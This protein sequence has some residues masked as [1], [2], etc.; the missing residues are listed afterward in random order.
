ML[1]CSGWR[2][3]IGIHPYSSA[4]HSQ[5]LHKAPWD[6]QKC[7]FFATSGRCYRHDHRPKNSESHTGN[8]SLSCNKWPFPVLLHSQQIPTCFCLSCCP[9]YILVHATLPEPEP[10]THRPSALLSPF[11]GAAKTMPS[12]VGTAEP[13]HAWVPPKAT[14]PKHQHCAALPKSLSKWAIVWEGFVQKNQLLSSQQ[15][16]GISSSKA[17]GSLLPTQPLSVLLDNTIG[18]TRNA[19]SC[20][21]NLPAFQTF[22]KGTRKWQ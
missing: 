7:L 13:L 17:T 4:L 16:L 8:H 3:N 22:K 2:I 15:D 21:G 12:S 1:V 19:P 9:L 6:K 10:L 20:L 5:D 18:F 14:E 11:S